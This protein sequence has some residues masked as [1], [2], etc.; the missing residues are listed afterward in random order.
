MILHP[1][2][3]GEIV[4]FP[5]H[6]LQDWRYCPVHYE[7]GVAK[8]T[9]THRRFKSVVRILKK[10]R[11]EMKRYGDRSAQNVPGYLLECMAWNIG[12]DH[13]SGSPWHNVIKTVLL[14][15]K[16]H[17]RTDSECESWREVDSIKTLFHQSQPWTR[18]A[19]YEFVVQARRY[20]GA[21]E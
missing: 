20:I 18:A 4:N 21:E 7:N 12:N 17:T 14:C 6:L 15:M 8:N 5:E 9:I 13:F 3:G 19:A 11:N 16:I 2:N 10:L 1:D